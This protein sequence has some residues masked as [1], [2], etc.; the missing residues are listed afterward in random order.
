[1]NAAKINFK[2]L[3][4]FD[5]ELVDKIYSLE[6]ENLGIDAALNQWQIPVL[7]R[8][9]RFIIIETDKKER[10]GVC[11]ILRCWHDFK[12][13]FIHSFYIKSEFRSLGI[14]GRFLKYIIDILIKEGFERIKL[15]V[16]PENIHAIKLYKKEGFK[17]INLLKDEYGKGLDRY[18]MQLNLVSKVK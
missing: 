9:G 11:Q 6:K 8:Y 17:I 16:D 4:N 14:G 5:N 3:K 10:I 1:M 2:I 7:I 15:T 12:D 18:M 13:A